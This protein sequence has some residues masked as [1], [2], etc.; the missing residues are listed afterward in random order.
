[1]LKP[2][3]V[4]LKEFTMNLKRNTKVKVFPPEAVFHT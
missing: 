2:V 3:Y 1:M 4:I